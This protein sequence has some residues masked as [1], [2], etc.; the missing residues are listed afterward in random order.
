MK[1]YRRATKNFFR[2]AFEDKKPNESDYNAF[3][4]HNISGAISMNKYQNNSA[5]FPALGYPWQLSEGTL[6]VLQISYIEADS[7]FTFPGFANFDTEDF[8][9]AAGSDMTIGGF[10]SALI[11][12]GFAAGDIFTLVA[13]YSPMTADDILNTSDDTVADISASIGTPPQWWIGQ[14]II[15][16]NNGSDLYD[17]S[18]IGGERHFDY[19]LVTNT[20]FLDLTPLDSGLFAMGCIVTRKKKNSSGL[21]ASTSYL[22]GNDVYN[23]MLENAATADYITAMLTSWG[24]D[25]T[26]AILAGDVAGGETTIDPVTGD[27]T[28]TTV[29]GSAVPA[30]LGQLSSGDVSLA[31]VGTNLGSETEV[32]ENSFAITGDSGV[33]SYVSVKSFTVHDSRSATL[34]LE[35]TGGETSKKFN[36]VAT[37]AGSQVTIATGTTALTDV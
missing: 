11:K 24:T 16:P 34:V 32:T 12:Y 4:R 7:T 36:V 3:M 25:T 21:L 31:I 33:G 17:M 28:I 29:N 9:G 14:F 30:A 10:S 20:R 37:L 35:S 18:S 26:T 19:D 27:P 5:V 15:D 6:P 13:V 8:G 22:V 1:F 2:F 23:A